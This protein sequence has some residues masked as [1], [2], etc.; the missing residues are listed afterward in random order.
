MY[1]IMGTGKAWAW[2]RR[3]RVEPMA[4]SKMLPLE[5]ELKTGAFKPM[6]SADKYFLQTNSRSKI[7]QRKRITRKTKFYRK[8]GAGKPC[9]GQSIEN[10]WFP[11][12][13]IGRV[14]I[15]ESL[16]DVDEIGSERNRKL[17]LI[18]RKRREIFKGGLDYLKLGAGKPWAGQSNAKEPLTGTSNGLASM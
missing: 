15:E 7:Q 18:V 13:I 4:R 3:L 2:H 11:D 16:G 9:A 5:S 14:S 1:L 6:G 17:I 12:A 8:A 10:D